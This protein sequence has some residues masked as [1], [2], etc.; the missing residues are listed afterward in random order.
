A[1]PEQ[2]YFSDGISE[3][4]TTALSR[5]HWLFVIART[6]AF[7]YKGRAVDVRQ[8]GRELG[9]RYVLEGSIRRD[10]G[11]VRITGQLNEASTGHHIWADR[12]DGELSDIFKLQDLVTQ[13]V[14]GAIEPSLQLAE[15]ARA[16]AKST[17]NL[18][19]YD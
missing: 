1:D 9:V 3:D 11:R 2:E 18:D 16:T 14:V 13:S 10:A 15:I 7:T 6:S 8:V 12:F 4:I 5:I 17:E 19:A